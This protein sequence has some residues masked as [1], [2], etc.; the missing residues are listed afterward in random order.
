MKRSEWLKLKRILILLI[1]ACSLSPSLARA[2]E[3]KAATT[4]LEKPRGSSNYRFGFAVGFFGIG[5]TADASGFTQV[6]RSEGPLVASVFVEMLLTD[7][8]SLGFEHYRGVSLAPFS[9]AASFTGLVSRYYFMGPAPSMVPLSDG[10][11]SLFVKSWTPF[12]GIS[13]GYAQATISRDN[14]QVPTVSGSAGYVGVTGGADYL[15]KPGVG[16]R[17]E[18][19]IASSQVP[20]AFSSVAQPP[21]LTLLSIQCGMFFNF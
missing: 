18:V 20:A 10:Q 11:S 3:P 1:A 6:P 15:L 9:T 8:I 14:D 21:E 2:Q 4:I 17:P 13:A 12:A 19:V 7:K 5:V 16:I